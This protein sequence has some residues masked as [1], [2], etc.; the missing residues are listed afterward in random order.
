MPVPVLP[1]DVA[2]RVITSAVSAMGAVVSVG[3]LITA[4]P[5]LVET[6]LGHGAAA[7]DLMLPILM[8]V[9]VLAALIAAL[10]LARTWASIAYLALGAVATVVYELAVLGVDPTLIDSGVYL[11]NR[12][13]LALVVISF[14]ASTTA[15]GILWCLAGWATTMALTGVVSLL[16]GVA[17]RP[18]LGPT[19]VL[20]VAILGYLT[21]ASIQTSR[22]RRV[23]DFD[24]LEAEMRKMESDEAL[25]RRS[26]AVIHDTVLNDLALIM[27]AP[28]RLDARARRR[29]LEDLDT[30][31]SAEWARATTAIATPNAV[32][33]GAVNDIARLL[34]DFQWRGLSVHVTSPQGPGYSIAPPVVE[35]LLGA[36]RAAFENVLRH[37][38]AKAAELEVVPAGTEI[39][40]MV[41]DRGIGFDPTQVPEDRLGVRSSIVD[42]ITA[43]GGRADIWSAPGEGTSVVITVPLV[44]P[45]APGPDG[46]A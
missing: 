19:I 34:S 1:R 20:V 2:G 31:Q 46:E 3:V 10:V 40:F 43:V 13:A 8:L 36:L 7:V 5:V 14:T 45:A 15:S 23:P 38:T 27:N 6:L 18:G 33:A 37:S 28:E 44:D 42:R 11:V 4:I 26:V 24:D 29:L 39:T 21:L 25:A 12:P 17:F 32:D 41:T 22:R 9:V 35:A 16:A 30:L